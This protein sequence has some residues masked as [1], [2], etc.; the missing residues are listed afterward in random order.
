MRQWTADETRWLQENYRNLG[1]KR[2]SHHL[3]RS[4]DSVQKKAERLGLTGRKE[5]KADQ[6]I[7][8]S[9]KSDSKIIALQDELRILRRK[10]RELLRSNKSFDEIVCAIK[11]YVQS[12]EPVF[13]PPPKKRHF[14]A[15]Y[16]IALLLLSDLHIDEVV[17]REETWGLAEYDFNIFCQ[18]LQ[19]LSDKIWHILFE[20]MAEYQINELIVACLGDFVSG[21]IH[22]ELLESA[23]MSVVE[24][25]LNGAYVLA[26]F[27][28]E[29]A[30]R[31]QKVRV[32]TVSGNHGRLTKTK[33]YKRRYAD[34]DRVLYET[35]GMILKD[36]RN[37][38]FKFSSAP[39]ALF[40]ANS[41]KFLME[42]GDAVRT[43]MSM[44][45]Y[46][47]ERERT[48]KKELLENITEVWD[49]R[50]KSIGMFHYM[51]LGHFHQCAQM[52]TPR[53]EVLINGSM[54]GGSEYSIGKIGV[55]HRPTQL[56][57]GVNSK[58]LISFRYPLRLDD[59][60]EVERYKKPPTGISLVNLLRQND[61]VSMISESDV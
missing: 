42:H 16:D 35:A 24:Q 28:R 1:L 18:R 48:R 33:R 41:A 52:D 57:V 21:A 51:L 46:G 40:E 49:S 5:G 23:S 17:S 31:F 39:F 59:A 61:D 30:Q 19:Y 44:P 22:D 53:G 54:V 20:C 25:A 45:W 27:L 9:V 55:A 4:W 37:V 15:P 8:E 14:E 6:D 56:L 13:I 7:I 10:Y 36:Q 58:G 2:C 34:W 3:R 43:W 60:P 47:I 29:Q 12:W 38:E 11:E 32:Y 26:Q 50:S